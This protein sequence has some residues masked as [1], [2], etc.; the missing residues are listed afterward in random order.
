MITRLRAALGL[1]A[2][3]RVVHDER[4]QVRQR[5]R[6]PRRAS[7]AAPSATLLPGSHSRLPCLPTCTT[8]VRS[9]HAAQPGVERE[10]AV[11]RHQ[12]RVVIGRADVDLVA[13]RRLD[14][15][16]RS[17]RAACPETTMRPVRTRGS[18]SGGP[19]RVLDGLH[20]LGRQRAPER[21]IVRRATGSAA[22]PRAS[23]SRR[24]RW[25]PSRCSALHQLRA[26][27]RQR[28]STA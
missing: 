18:R 24:A 22:Q 14:A 16:E 10:V 13:A 17:R 5:R 25:S 19:Q 2:L 7:S 1:R 26:V 4:I 21:A 15:D 9:I 23:S 6:T 27:L 11:R 12:I 28:R 8:R 3:A 20:E